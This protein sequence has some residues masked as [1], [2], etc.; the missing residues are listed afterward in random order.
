MATNIGTGP[1]DI[2]LNQFL[3]EM[4]FVDRPPQRVA[5]QARN[6]ANFNFGA[7]PQILPCPSVSVNIAGCY[8]TTTYKFTAPVDGVY[9]FYMAVSI[10]NN[11]AD[12]QD[13]S[14][15][16]AFGINNT[17]ATGNAGAYEYSLI[18]NPRTI[19]GGDA[20]GTEMGY[21]FSQII[22]LSAGDRVDARCV[23][24]T[25]TTGGTPFFNRAFFSGFQI[26]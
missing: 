16:L 5:F 13:D 23:E 9:Y 25:N 10:D 7:N 22:Q 15:G 12:T 20:I 26:T 1:Q 19:Q 2:P 6:T 3:G 17:S 14:G 11:G 8:D 18:C 21:S 4:A 24:W